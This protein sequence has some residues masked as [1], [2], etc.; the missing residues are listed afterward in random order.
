MLGH[1][2]MYQDNILLLSTRNNIYTI[3]ENGD[4][5]PVKVLFYGSLQQTACIC[6]KYTTY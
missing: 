4:F 3:L 6:W 1:T 2:I 5:F